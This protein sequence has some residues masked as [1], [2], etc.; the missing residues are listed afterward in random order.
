MP[1]S[2]Q[3]QLEIDGIGAIGTTAAAVTEAQKPKGATAGANREARASTARDAGSGGAADAG[4]MPATVRTAVV[5]RVPGAVMA[6]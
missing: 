3:L 1:L 5:R 6:S 2:P 4:K